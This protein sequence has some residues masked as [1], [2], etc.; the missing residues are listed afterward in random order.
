[1]G[2]PRSTRFPR[3]SLFGISTRAIACALCLLATASSAV[4]AK[5]EHGTASPPP[6]FLV[7]PD[8][9]G[10]PMIGYDTT[11]GEKRFTLPAGL[12]TADGKRYVSASAS[13]RETAIAVYEPAF[14]QLIVRIII[15]GSWEVRGVSA[16]GDWLGLRRIPSEPERAAWEAGNDRQTEIAIMDTV[17]SR[18]THEIVLDGDFDID[19]LSKFG[20]SL[21]LLQ[22]LPSTG[23][24]HYA[25]RLYDL[26]TNVLQ[27]AP[28]RDKR[29]PDEEMFGYAWGGT[30]T[31]NGQWLLTLYMN[32]EE[33]YAFIH[34]LNLANRYP[35]C[36]DLPW[37]DSDFAKL[38]AYSLTVAPDGR[39]VYAANPVIGKLGLVDLSTME[40]VR[41]VTFP[42]VTPVPPEDRSAARSLLSP[43]G[44]MLYFTAGR[45]VWAYDTEAGEIVHSYQAPPAVAG[46]GLSPDGTRLLIVALDGQVTAIDLASGDVVSLPGA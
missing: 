39:H 16:T 24:P 8:G 9:L 27:E 30:A 38:K 10:G 12:L 26:T 19:G 4:V 6:P 28:L 32:T 31:P 40:V 14:G 17:S 22:H 33:G 1:M 46:L 43:D 37:T 29:N 44:R 41:T 45:I 15:N 23:A 35:V 11:T 20:E 7:R 42:A 13:G 5:P 25:I 18:I 34:S 36:I 2:V 21:Y 3:H